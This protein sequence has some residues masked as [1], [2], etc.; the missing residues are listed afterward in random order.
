LISDDPV[1]AIQEYQ[2]NLSN[3]IKDAA[4]QSIGK[5]RISH[6]QHSHILLEATQHRLMGHHD[7]ANRILDQM[8][9]DAY[10]TWQNNG[11]EMNSCEFAK[12]TKMHQK[13][14][15]TATSSIDVTNMD[16]TFAQ[17]NQKFGLGDE[18]NTPAFD[19]RS[20]EEGRWNDCTLEELKEIIQYLPKN[21][22]AG[23]D[24]IINEFFIFATDRY[25]TLIVNLFNALGR[26]GFLPQ[27][28][29]DND[30][31]PVH[32]NRVMLFKFLIYY[33]P[34]CLA[35]HFKKLFECILDPRLENVFQITNVQFGYQEDTSTMDAGHFFQNNLLELKDATSDSPD[36]EDEIVPVMAD[37]FSA[38]D[39][40]DQTSFKNWVNSLDLPINIKNIL[41]HLVCHQS[42]RLKVGPNKSQ[43][44]SLTKGI[45]QGTKLSPKIFIKLID[46]CM[47]GCPLPTIWFVDD[48]LFMCKRRDLA[49]SL[50]LINEKLSIIRLRIGPEKTKIM[51]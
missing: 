45:L 14:R 8:Q 42:I 11:N 1:P 5:T 15:A 23:P 22:A 34:I 44:K 27:E 31:T 40:I 49:S 29:L 37:V 30:I 3:M 19:P 39:E 26:L 33:R 38:F 12:R 18:L 13:R 28:Y 43:F 24:D 51:S 7:I 17:W 2:T 6:V 50:A 10:K 16:S 4:N 36:S 47:T 35:S 9:K 21:K 20:R 41:I 46:F 25:L 48:L 32:K